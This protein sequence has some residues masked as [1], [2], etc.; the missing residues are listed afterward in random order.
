MP[1]APAASGLAAKLRLLAAPVVAVLPFAA[2]VSTALRRPPVGCLLYAFHITSQC[3]L[4]PTEGLGG[5]C[6]E[7]MSHMVAV[8]LCRSAFRGICC[9]QRCR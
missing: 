1:Q 5:T 2:Q 4:H 8:F 6:E 7:L 3:G 9:C